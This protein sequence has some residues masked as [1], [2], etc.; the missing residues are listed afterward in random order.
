MGDCNLIPRTFFG[1]VEELM[2]EELGWV[3]GWGGE[4]GGG[5]RVGR[6]GAGRGEGE[7]V[8]S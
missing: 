4:L 6:G 8:E 1:G 3:G 2:W 7:W 5:A